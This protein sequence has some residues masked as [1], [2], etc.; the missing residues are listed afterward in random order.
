MNDGRRHAQTL[1]MDSPP[2]E[3]S[4]ADRH[5]WQ[6]RPIGDLLWIGVLAILALILYHLREIFVPV[7][8]GLGLAYLA[9]PMIDWAEQRL[10]FPPA[11]TVAL[12]LLV[13]ALALAGLGFWLGPL[14]VGQIV[15]LVK[16][17]P[18][19]LQAVARQLGWRLDLSHLSALSTEFTQHLEKN[20][21]EALKPVWAGTGTTLNFV[22]GMIGTTTYLLITLS[23]L[24]IYFWCFAL[25]MHATVDR[26]LEYVPAS[27]RPW[28]REILAK[29]DQA[30]GSYIH[31]RVIVSAIM[32][33]AFAI[34]W[35][36]LLTNVPYWLVVALLA[37]LL[38]LIPYGAGLGWLVALALK[39]IAISSGPSTGGWQWLLGLGGPTAVFAVVQGAEHSFMTPWVQSRSTH[40]S[41]VTV[42]I[43]LLVAGA[44]AGILGMIIAIPVAA[45]A[46]ILLQETVLG[47]LA[48]QA[49][50]H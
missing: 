8:I 19:D 45:C 44:L 27:R 15:M 30:A 11:L 46:K 37:A 32:G 39:A 16:Q 22:E 6:I 36:P 50:E 14:I 4:W 48:A 40:L 1:R 31:G 20:P 47:P 7:L 28:A 23:L 26:L 43:A 25:R 5:L 13:L 2:A 41:L 17:V 42:I 29:M 10:G 18:A 3:R 33:V 21:I 35:S 12:L 49:K 34:G 24:P 38:S 9:L